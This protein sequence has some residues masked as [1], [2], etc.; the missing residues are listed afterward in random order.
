MFYNLFK[1]KFRDI[2]MILIYNLIKKSIQIYIYIY[3]HLSVLL[4]DPLANFH[5]FKKQK[6]L[7]ALM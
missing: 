3:R 7:G 2:F 4:M 6:F 5:H 1:I